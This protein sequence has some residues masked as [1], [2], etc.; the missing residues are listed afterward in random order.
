MFISFSCV[1]LCP[2]GEIFIHLLVLVVLSLDHILMKLLPSLDQLS[3]V[4]VLL[5]LI[6]YVTLILIILTFAI[7]VFFEA[8]VLRIDILGL[9]REELGLAND[10]IGFLLGTLRVRLLLL[11]QE[12]LLMMQGGESLVGAIIVVLLLVIVV[13]IVVIF[14]IQVGWLGLLVS[15]LK[16]VL[17]LLLQLLLLHDRIVGPRTLGAA[18]KALA[19]ATLSHHLRELMNDL[20]ELQAMVRIAACDLHAANVLKIH[21]FHDFFLQQVN[22]SLDVLSDLLIGLSRL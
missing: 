7:L 11:L 6:V 9:L 16:V 14:I 8:V 12:L 17:L 20:E 18:L 5:L 4:V 3:I 1:L 21:T 2:Q 19:A 13:T 10:R 22:E 15:D